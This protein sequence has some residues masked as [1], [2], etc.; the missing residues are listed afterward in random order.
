MA[1]EE[2]DI[3]A[4]DSRPASHQRYVSHISED[5]TRIEYVEDH[6]NEVAALAGEF[7]SSFGAQRLG[8]CVGIA[9]DIGKYSK[10]FQNRILNNGLKVDHSTP[11]A[12][13]LNQLGSWCG[14]Y[15][16]MGHHGGLPDGGVE[17]DLGGTYFGRLTN[18][19][20]GT[21]PDY[22]A[23]SRE[24]KLLDPPSLPIRL[25]PGW[26]DKQV[27]YSAA[28]FTRMLFSCLVDADYLCTERF[29]MGKSREGIGSSSLS[30]L[31]QKFENHI[32]GFY[33]PQNAL[34]ETRCR[35]L[36]ACLEAAKSNPGVFS[37]TVPTGGGKTLASLRFALNHACTPEH[38]M[39]RVI[40]AVPYTSIIE[41][42]ARV[43]RDILGEENVLEH[44]ANFD[45]DDQDEMGEKLRL[46]SENWDALV[47]V[48]TNV[49]FF[50]SLYSNKTSRC[51]KLHAVAGSVIVLDEAQ[52]L[53][54][55]QLLPCVRALVEL[56]VNYGCSVVLC[57]ATQ[58]SLGGYF[59]GYG[60][61]VRE[62][63][64]QPSA[65]F[66]AL[67][68]VAYK[69]L[70][71]IEDGD[72]VDLLKSQ[73]QALCIVNSR[74]QARNLFELLQADGQCGVFHLTTLMH[75]VHREQV[76]S[77]IRQSLK[78]G[79]EC[80]VIA[81]SLVEAG[82]DL[83]FPIVY[84]SMAGVDSI[85]QAAG[86]CNREGRAKATDSNVLVFS[87]S[88]DYSLP[89]DVKQKCAVTRD[90]VRECLGDD[91]SSIGSLKSIDGY[92]KRLYSYR[93]IDKEA[94]LKSLTSYCDLGPKGPAIPFADVANKFR[95]IDDSSFSVVIPDEAIADE[96]GELRIA[97]ATRG[98]MR[99]L[100]RYSVSLYED[101]I[102]RLLSAGAIEPL[103]EN[104]FLL[105]DE[106]RYDD[107]VGLDVRTQEG[108][109][110]YW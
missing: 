31:R 63:A 47:I 85:I 4:G 94:V 11:G 50:E 103:A 13:E 22:S 1:T 62:I 6:L 83:D 25:L 23:F 40:Y 90:V 73:H 76:L 81:T 28:F 34:N 89:S 97:H 33:P 110:I 87:P 86:R 3:L 105:V 38:G 55:S 24:V 35:V 98:T 95:V 67:N 78:D 68:R 106:A 100:S 52:M 41:Q 16:V 82:V 69:Q 2:R 64:P 48:T 71:K 30:E 107:Q 9:H 51:R 42:N 70:G 5:G 44:H 80:R 12:Y 108:S 75:P 53:P 84:R 93:Q 18:V 45:F 56:V 96:I 20:R 92:F 19:S 59:S 60:V 39:K 32:R 15:C 65:L 109:G 49:Q 21:V 101:D 7:A 102:K 46:A 26:D 66:A 72:L 29:M 79:K 17:S 88:A 77:Y 37:L 61:P 99:R 43:F 27:K 54:T 74:K 8:E 104:L 36:D 57:T 91:I 58:P 14:A 10:E